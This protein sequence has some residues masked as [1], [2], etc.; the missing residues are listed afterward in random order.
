[1]NL[2]PFL[3]IL[4]LVPACTSGLPKVKVAPHSGASDKQITLKDAK[5]GDALQK[6]SLATRELPN[7]RL[8]YN[9][10]VAEA[11]LT[12]QSRLSPH[13]WKGKVLVESPVGRWELSFHESSLESTN[14]VELPPSVADRLI[15]ADR[16][17][18][19]AYRTPSRRDGTGFPV[20]LALDEDLEALRKARSFRAGNGIYA[21]GTA[22]LDF[23]PPSMPGAP[24]QV[25]LRVVNSSRQEKAPLAGS[26]YPIAYDR[27][28]ALHAT[29]NNDYVRKNGIRGLLRADRHSHDLGLFGIDGYQRG[30]IPVVFVHGLSSSPAIW[31]QAIHEM[32]A[33]SRLAAR[34]QPLL[35]IYPTGLNVPA[36]AARLRESLDRY[37]SYWDPSSSDRAF[38]QMVIIGHSM[39]GI[40]TRLQTLETGEE[41][42]RAFFTRPISENPWLTSEQKQGM[43]KSLVL[44]PLPYVKRVIFIAVPHRGSEVADLSIVKLVERLIRLP[45]QTALLVTRAAKQDG[46]Q[47]LNPALLKYRSLGLRSVDMLSAKHPYFKALDRIPIS[48]PY[49][50]IIGDRGKAEPCENSSD[51][52]VPYWSSHLE[53]AKSEKL[54]PHGH[55]CTQ[56]E[57]T[58]HEVLRILRLHASI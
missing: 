37:R 57:E 8:S 52:I 29:L 35:F 18:L 17:D 51:G 33:D 25:R 13:A 27:T 44:H 2:R 30:K 41:L 16:F 48:V 9:Q 24:A 45:V 12:L 54:V 20:V 19:S 55:S 47:L 39:G 53:T 42:R 21:A 26:T 43:Q 5:L 3:L 11:V 6:A 14:L 34:F 36:A 58:L 46:I 56:A 23:T 22:L 32:Q 28:A 7:A 4:L 49:H 15:P 31:G 1:M 10:A 40:L 50:S 38:D